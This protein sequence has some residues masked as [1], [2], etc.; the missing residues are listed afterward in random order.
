[1]EQIEDSS[2]PPALQELASSLPVDERR[3]D[4]EGVFPVMDENRLELIVVVGELEP[5]LREILLNIYLNDPLQDV[6]LLLP[7]HLFALKQL[8][9]HLSMVLY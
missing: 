6:S 9:E 5:H 3:S 2:L 7:T 4:E 1:M 8:R